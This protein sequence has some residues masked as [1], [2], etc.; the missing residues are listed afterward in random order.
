MS[1]AN[2]EQTTKRVTVIGALVNLV[3]SIAKVVA[4]V[5]GHSAALVADGIHSLSD[6][7]SDVMV[8][9]AAHHGH[10]DADDDHPYGHGRF[11]TL[12]TAALGLLLIAVALGIGIDAVGRLMDT[13]DAVIPSQ[14][15]LWVTV[16]AIAS[17]EF[18]YHYTVAAAQRINSAMLRAN[19]WH[20]RSDAVSSIV[21]L[22]GIVGAQ[23]GLP[24]LDP[25][26][27]LVVGV[28]V[29]RIGWELG[30]GAVEELVDK[31]LDPERLEEIERCIESVP[32]V[33]DLH[34]LRTRRIGSEALADVHIL[35]DSRVSVSEG[36]QIAEEVRQALVRD[37]DELGDVTVHIDP[38]DDEKA[39][40]CAG[41]PPRHKVLEDVQDR[42]RE[43]G[44]SLV[45]AEATLHYLSGRVDVEVNLPLSEV[46]DPSKATELQDTLR[47]SVKPIR[48][49]GGLDV[50]FY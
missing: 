3:L 5:I 39:P 1:T 23:W 42:F 12:A 41:L 28:M 22:V 21:V 31:G 37:I 26:A 38:E 46:P 44:V 14:L 4:G 47:E 27:A 50:R 45:P 25:V 2:R 29:A 34:M 18:L 49:L 48:Y 16:I 24:L 15:T 36:H 10:K 40:T 20:H 33:V 35:V 7:A 8:W 32:G 30:W 9:V 11:E 19:A 17:K 6:L 43:A 13:D